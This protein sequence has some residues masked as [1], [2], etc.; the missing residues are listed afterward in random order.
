MI[1]WYT[2]HM[3]V[4]L[5]IS[6]FM[7]LVMGMMMFFGAVII[8]FFVFVAVANWKLFEKAGKPGWASLIPVYNVVVLL[9]IIGYKWYYIFFFFLG[10][11][12]LIGWVL[13]MLF[14]VSF[15]FKLAKSFGQT[16]L[17]GVGLWLLSPVFSAIIGFSK[18]INYVGPAVNGDV[19][20]NDLF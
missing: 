20:F 13:S 10:I 1:L 12:P 6:D 8:A 17:F 4:G 9:D 19:D 3:E 2:N 16:N 7:F 18:D 15:S 5:M 11:V 14:T